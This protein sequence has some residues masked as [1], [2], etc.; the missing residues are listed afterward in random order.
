VKPEIPTVKFSLL[1][2]TTNRL[3]LVERLLHS[4]AVQTYGNFEVILVH[5]PA[6]PED[7]RASAGRF[8][9]LNIRLLTSKDHCLSRS[10]NLALT[11]TTGD[12]I[13]FPDDDCVYCPDTLK[14]AASLFTAHPEAEALLAVREDLREADVLPAV[15]K[16]L[17][18][19]GAVSGAR[20]GAALPSVNRYA[21]FRHSG[22]IVQ[23]YRKQCVE[24]VGPFDERLGPGT[25]LPYGCGEDTD[26][27]LRALA[28]GFGVYRAPAVVV[29]HAPMNIREAGISAKIEAYARGRMYL[30]RKHGLPAWF[31][32]A[33]IAWP[34]FC[35]P[36]ECLRECRAVVRF[37]W[38]M[39]RARLSSCLGAAG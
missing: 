3:H 21:A 27:V 1:I 17:Q 7:A 19:A 23:F 14:N 29:R 35:V 24:V 34:L 20:A 32:A 25:G 9:G 15:Q 13:A 6:C 33:N 26:Y 30:L 22:T 28:A 18:E 16:N 10:R 31:V 39:F 37:R 2:V 36:G 12:I 8:P 38:D 5:G 4:L 11:G